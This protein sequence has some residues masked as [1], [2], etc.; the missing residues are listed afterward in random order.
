MIDLSADLAEGAPGE[1]E[2]WPMINSANVACGGHVGDEQS[3]AGAVR[4]ARR[5]NVRLGAHPSYPDRANFGR[6]SMPMAPPALRATLIEQI[7]ALRGIA[8]RE[9]VPLRHVK[10]HGA[11][12]NDAHKDL[13]L[14]GVIIEAI[15]EVDPQIAIVCP[16]VSEMAA[17]ARG[18]GTPVIREAFADRRYNPDGSLVTRSVAGS[19]L[20]VE[21][22]AEQAELLVRERVV[23][24]RDGS[25]VPIAFDTICI[26][27]DMENAVERLH[28]IRGRL[29]DLE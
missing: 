15:R 13:V 20:S 22:A 6:M 27:A 4:L 8:G 11:L 12:Y 1:D 25:R 18:S 14:A 9:G 10:P 26:H 24:A 29:G 3:M 5:H 7:K 19:L 28:A 16:N 23:I 17:A 2:I 21:E